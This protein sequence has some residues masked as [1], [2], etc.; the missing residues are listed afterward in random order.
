MIP[1]TL[2]TVVA[3]ILVA[4]AV[5]AYLPARRA[6]GIDPTETLRDGWLSATREP[7]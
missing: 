1:T 3:T 2:S 5:A 6:A 7:D 4:T